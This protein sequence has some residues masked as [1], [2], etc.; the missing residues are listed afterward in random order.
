MI[1]LFVLALVGMG[2]T[3]AAVPVVVFALMLETCAERANGAK[4][5]AGSPRR[6]PERRGMIR[7][8]SAA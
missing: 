3:F 4:K 5:A 8:A 2:L 1:T 7:L 6:S